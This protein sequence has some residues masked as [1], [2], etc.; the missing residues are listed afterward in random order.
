MIVIYFIRLGLKLLPCSTTG[1]TIYHVLRA[2]LQNIV[3]FRKVNAPHEAVKSI[4]LKGL[5]P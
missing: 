4:E 5:A 1:R 3:L 2:K